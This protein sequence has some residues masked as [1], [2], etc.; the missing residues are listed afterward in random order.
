MNVS[1]VLWLIPTVVVAGGIAL[2]VAIAKLANNLRERRRGIRSAQ[3]IAA[4]GELVSRRSL[5]KHP[6][7]GWADDLLFCDALAEYRLSIMGADRGHVD[8]LVDH[9]GIR[10]ALWNR[11]RKTR[12]SIRRLRTVALWVDLAGPAD[13]PRLVELLDDRDQYVAIHAAKGLSRIGSVESVDE[14]LDRMV[15]ADPWHAARLADSLVD[16]NVRIGPA[17]RV[18]IGDR[19]CA[20]MP[21]TQSIALAIRILGVIGDHR[22]ESMLMALVDHEDPD[23]RI[24]TA[25]A[26][27]RVGSDRCVDALV[28]ATKDE[29]WPV[30]AR[31]AASLGRLGAERALDALQYLLE[32][33]EWW[34]RQNAAQAI[35]AIPGGRPVLI[36]ALDG[37]DPYAADAALH[38]LTTSGAI[39]EAERRIEAGVAVGRDEALVAHVR[40][41]GFGGWRASLHTVPT[42][43]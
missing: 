34:V 33:R 28:V 35:G 6:P 42:V 10:D 20:D 18:W 22:A 29:V 30:R 13:T 25:S 37:T 3:Y 2:V 1:L 23:I 11:I 32:D 26:L 16:Y 36:D 38:Q 5:P 41:I 15:H 4:I 19:L 9:I 7:R 14:I 43:A 21:P 27:G 40:R 12:S 17:I 39:E 31:A 8:A 24:A